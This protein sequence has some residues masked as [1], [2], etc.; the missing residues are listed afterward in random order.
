MI[1][2]IGACFLMSAVM[3]LGWNAIALLLTDIETIQGWSRTE[4]SL[5]FSILV[6]VYTLLT[7]FIGVLASRYDS[8]VVGCTL[9]IVLAIG[10]GVAALANTVWQFYLGFGLL[11]GIGS[12][13][14]ASIIIFSLLI[15]RVRKR[16]TT[17]IAL[18]DSGTGFGMIAGF[19]V[20]HTVV[21]AYSW[22]GAL[23]FLA[24]LALFTGLALY[25]AVLPPIRRMAGKRSRIG[26][27]PKP[28]L[29]LVCLAAAAFLGAA[30]L[31]GYQSHQ[32]A[33]VD[34]LSGDRSMAVWIASLLGGIIFMWRAASGACIDRYGEGVAA[35]LCIGFTAIACTAIYLHGI[36]NAW[37]LLGVFAIGI[38]VG[39]GGQGILVAAGTR[40]TFPRQAF[41]PAYGMIRLSNG[42]GLVAGPVVAGIGYDAFGHYGI[43]IIIF[44]TCAVFHF[45]LFCC[46][47]RF[48]A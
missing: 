25:G 33:I 10:F 27:L 26:L 7:P 19:P 39:L 9:A 15:D 16:T 4:I 42:I 32:I 38:G 34:E 44:L 45:L 6:L 30:T 5:G 43:V 46:A 24:I 47:L 31:Q 1:I 11:A 40:R 28:A 37:P 13:A 12:H 14:F 41:A 20:L 3:G 36:L 17:A 8:R 35:A 29:G 23:V 2:L 18:A 48:S 22:R 21:T